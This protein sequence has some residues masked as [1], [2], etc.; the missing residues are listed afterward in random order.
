MTQISFEPQFHPLQ[1]FRPPWHFRSP[2]PP[3]PHLFLPF[4]PPPPPSF[5][6]ANPF[7]RFRGPH[8]GY[9]PL[10]FTREAPP[11]L[12]RRVAPPPVSGPHP[13]Y[14]PVPFKTGPFPPW[15]R[16]P[17]VDEVA[18]EEEEAS[19]EGFRIFDLDNGSTFE[20]EEL[21]SDSFE[22]ES[23]GAGSEKEASE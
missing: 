9:G 16:G 20:V 11:R 15:A 23:K 22:D 10:P 17:E 21:E 18:R 3:P 19:G 1:R 5:M 4:G 6:S 12:G 2:F 13:G 7:L 8:P 14:E